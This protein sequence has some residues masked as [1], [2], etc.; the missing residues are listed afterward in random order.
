MGLDG[1]SVHFP[2]GEEVSLGIHYFHH[3]FLSPQGGRG[4][5]FLS[6]LDHKAISAH[7]S[8]HAKSQVN[9]V[10]GNEP[11]GKKRI[12]QKAGIF[13]CKKSCSGALQFCTMGW[14][15]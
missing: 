6:I 11:L 8:Q 14:S 9:L 1:G 5:N 4:R 10:E 12:L 15:P 7:T 3:S 2:Q 13:E